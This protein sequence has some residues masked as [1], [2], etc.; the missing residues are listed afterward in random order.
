MTCNLYIFIMCFLLFQSVVCRESGIPEGT[1]RGWLKDESKLR[2]FVDSVDSVDGLCRKKARTAK[3]SHLDQALF[4]WFVQEQS[5]SGTPVSGPIL[6]AQAAKMHA[7]LHGP[8]APEFCASTGWLARFR[9]RH[10][11]VYT[12]ITGDVRSADHEAAARFP[13]EF[14]AYVEEHGLCDDQIYNT[15]ETALYSRMLPD[16]T[17]ALRTDTT[18]T[19]GFKQSKDR[20][21][22][23][24]TV[25]K[26]GSHKLKPLVIGRYNNP[27][28]L[29]NVNRSTLPVEYTHSKNAWMTSRLFED[30]F[31]NTFVPQV[32]AHLLD[33]DLEPRAVLLLD[34]CPAHPPASTLTS[35]DGKITVLY[36][37]KNT[38]S[39][40]QPLDQ[41]IIQNFKC[42]YRKGLVKDIV[43]SPLP[44]Q[45]FIKELT[46]KDAFYLIGA[47]W[48]D[49]KQSS[50][51]NCWNHALPGISPVAPFEEDD[52]EFLGFSQEEVTA[53]VRKFSSIVDQHESFPAMVEDWAMADM[54][55]PV[56]QTLT[57]EEL[58]ADA[59]HA[60]DTEPEPE[61]EPE[62]A[63]P[64]SIPTTTDIVDMFQ[65][66]LQ[67]ME[68]KD[69]DCVKTMQLKWM[70]NFSK[71]ELKK[72]Q[73]QGSITEFFKKM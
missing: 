18:K 11:I 17:L 47:A 34:N 65:K 20:V 51:I 6:Q 38:T 26:T 15:D 53:A 19:H 70:L 36:L 62:T 43:A 71:S 60:E 56:T 63:Q 50:I 40:I 45:Q 72:S 13:E 22:L 49:V 52:E 30:W 33:L 25:N 9:K 46:L 1:L 41:G 61:P 48:H 31:K 2:D 3:D 57:D 42:N 55:V 35:R 16:H 64:E 67:W 14:R 59:A 21:T 69:V 12:K 54:D 39:K 7:T 10:G 66:C 32:R 44:I 28:C 37:P 24:L 4:G 27:R 68:T 58:L 29:K 8:E 5:M 23:L 73:R